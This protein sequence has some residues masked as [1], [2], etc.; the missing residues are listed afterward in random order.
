MIL[1]KSQSWESC[2]PLYGT[3]AICKLRSPHATILSYNSLLTDYMIGL[4]TLKS[5]LTFPNTLII[6]TWNLVFCCQV[7]VHAVDLEVF[8]ALVQLFVFGGKF[9]SQWHCIFM[10][11]ARAQL[12]QK[13]CPLVNN[14]CGLTWGHGSLLGWEEEDCVVVG[15]RKGFRCSDVDG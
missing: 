6:P 9:Y 12:S 7:L 3:L 11:W 13:I 15:L 8:E 14:S 1:S 2:S 4:L 5:S 10:L